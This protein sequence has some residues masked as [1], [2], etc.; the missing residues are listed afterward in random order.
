MKNSTIHLDIRLDEK[1]IPEKIDWQATDAEAGNHEAT[2]MLLALWDHQ[3]KTGLSIDLW[4]KE[5]TIPEMNLFFYQ[6]LATLG[7]TFLRATK[8]KALSDEITT[9]AKHFF[10]KIK[11]AQ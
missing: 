11:E 7:E 6:T 1:N 3:Q 2:A 8:N 5:M 9:F 10:E 4:T